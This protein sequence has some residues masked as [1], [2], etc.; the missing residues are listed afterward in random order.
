MDRKNNVENIITDN[1]LAEM[2]NL[3]SDLRYMCQALINGF[4]DDTLALFNRSIN[5][6]NNQDIDDLLKE[7]VLK[8][9]YEI[10]KKNTVFTE[11][12]RKW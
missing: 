8:R 12:N 4:L 6:S 2:A 5:Q 9:Y 11:K 1:L 7:K 10:T 3:E